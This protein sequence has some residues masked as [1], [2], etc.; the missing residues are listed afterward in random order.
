MKSSGHYVNI[1]GKETLVCCS[2]T[3]V[4]SFDAAYF[5]ARKVCLLS[6]HAINTLI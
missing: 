6:E 2:E 4:D 5:K 3:K 1:L